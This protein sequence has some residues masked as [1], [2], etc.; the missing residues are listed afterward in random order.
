M[1]KEG[2]KGGGG[3]A[4]GAKAIL[5]RDGDGDGGV[6]DDVGRILFG[7]RGEGVVWA[8]QA[9]GVGGKGGK[10]SGAGKGGGAC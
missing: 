2:A 9:L 10:A 3:M 5:D 1:E 8:A 6:L 4:G 7:E